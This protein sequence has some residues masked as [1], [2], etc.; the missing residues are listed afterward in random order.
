MASISFT[1]EVGAAALTNGVPAPGD[2]FTG[3]TPMT[4]PVGPRETSRGTGRLFRFVFRRDY[5]ARLTLGEIPQASL[6]VADRLVAFLLAGGVVSVDTGDSDGNV[7]AT[8]V[9]A[10]ETEP[11]LAMEDR[12]DLTYSLSLA[13]VNVAAA[14]VRM[15]CN[16]TE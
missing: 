15:L 11:E 5:G 10:P 7:Y 16:Y 13:L 4:R 12:H 9:L 3:W 2:R 14:P 8:C 1:D 6:D